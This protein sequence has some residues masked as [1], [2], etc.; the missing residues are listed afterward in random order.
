MKHIAKEPD[1]H[2]EIF[3]AS[4]QTYIQKHNEI[5]SERVLRKDLPTVVDVGNTQTDELIAPDEDF[6][7]EERWATEI[8]QKTGKRPRR[9]DYP[10][11]PWE[12]KSWRGGPMMW[13]YCELV[14][15]A[16]RFKIRR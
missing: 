4:R 14:G 15:T 6:V 7:M 8:E 10:H 13:G 2:V 1:K 3:P 16:G 5:P 12:Q 9:Q 11:L